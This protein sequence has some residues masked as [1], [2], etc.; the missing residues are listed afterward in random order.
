MGE[1]SP[2]S[3]AA[4]VR[5]ETVRTDQVT[6]DRRYFLDYTRRADLPHNPLRYDFRWVDIE[7]SVI[8]GPFVTSEGAY[9]WREG[10][11]FCLHGLA[12]EPANV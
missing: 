9:R 2:A 5:E 7:G 4:K 1:L 3:D 11:D 10:Y 8:A 12:E 6:N